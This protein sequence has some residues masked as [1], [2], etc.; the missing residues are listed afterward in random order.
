MV[1]SQAGPVRS[2]PLAEF[3]QQGWANVM[4]SPLTAA[5]RQW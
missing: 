1:E 5:I 4:V 2:V 3:V